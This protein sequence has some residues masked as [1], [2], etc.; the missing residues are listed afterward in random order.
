MFMN[1]RVFIIV[2]I[3]ILFI[4]IFI[5]FYYRDNN[6]NYRWDDKGYLDDISYDVPGNFKSDRYTYSD[7]Y[8]YYNNSISCSFNVK[9]FSVYDISNGEEYLKDNIR[10]TLNDEVSDISLVDLNGDK[11]YYMT[12]NRRSDTSY[13]YAIIKNDKGYVLEYEINDY[14]RGDTDKKDNF[15]YVSY[16]KII[17]SVKLK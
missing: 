16:D 8:H 17:S 5:F 3:V 7:N 10:F 6:Y 12:V 11:W 13:Y 15:C 2:G 4:C 14:L 9:Y 1:K